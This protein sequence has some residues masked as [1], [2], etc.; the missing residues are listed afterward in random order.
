[1]NVA[2]TKFTYLLVNL[3]FSPLLAT[4]K[5]RIEIKKANR[6]I[7][8]KKVSFLLKLRFLPENYIAKSKWPDQ[9]LAGPGATYCNLRDAFYKRN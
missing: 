9:G 7:N 1:M 4:G 3:K 5:P 6:S 8:L 2:K